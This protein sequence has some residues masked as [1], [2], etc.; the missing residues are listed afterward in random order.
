MRAILG[1]MVEQICRPIDTKVCAIANAT[2]EDGDAFPG[3][4]RSA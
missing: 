1:W 4:Y 3:Y 2:D